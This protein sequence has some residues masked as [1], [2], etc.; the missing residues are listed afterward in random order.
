MTKQIVRILPN[1]AT[2]KARLPQR[3]NDEYQLKPQS[4]VAASKWAGTK[5]KL[6]LVYQRLCFTLYNFWCLFKP[7]SLAYC[8]LTLALL[9]QH[10][11]YSTALEGDEYFCCDCPHCCYFTVVGA[12]KSV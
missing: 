4:D 5:R 12:A 9:R 8:Y 1:L 3:L 2:L 6:N 11:C 10:G 7:L